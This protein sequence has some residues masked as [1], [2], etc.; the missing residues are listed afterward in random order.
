MFSSTAPLYFSAE[1]SGLLFSAQLRIVVLLPAML[2]AQVSG[3]LSSA[4]I[5]K[6]I[7]DPH[8]TIKRQYERP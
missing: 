5:P 8:A 6:A 2:Q 3:C 7:K 4:V 1:D